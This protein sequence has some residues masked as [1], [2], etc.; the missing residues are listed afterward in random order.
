MNKRISIWMRWA[1][2]FSLTIVET[3]THAVSKT[4]SDTTFN[5]ADFSQ[6]L[7]QT[8]GG[9]VSVSQTTTDGNPG[10]AL[11]VTTDAPATH[12]LFSAGVYFVRNSFSW[13]PASD[14]NLYTVSWNE[15]VYLTNTPSATTSIGGDLF[16]FQAGNYYINYQDLPTIT[17]VFQ[18]A[19]ATNLTASAFSLVVDLPSG[20][21]NSN[22]HPDFT[23]PLTFGLLSNAFQVSA[24]SDH[25][26]VKVDNLLIQAISEI[27]AAD[28]NGNHSVDAADYVYWRNFYG[29]AARYDLWRRNFGLTIASGLGSGG[30]LH[31]IPE[32]T[33]CAL[34]M[35]A[36]LA[37][38]LTRLVLRSNT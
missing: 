36:L 24:N 7:F 37:T 16:I 23:K 17:G 28:F 3:P 9:T 6:S 4:F 1:I 21:T 11:L 20:D 26:V 10:S 25:T 5:L 12:A 30:S 32:P 14:G 8:G 22:V 15:D 19:A 38:V 33:N 27:T 31:T 35:L 13:N 34:A 18:T 2:L 29:D